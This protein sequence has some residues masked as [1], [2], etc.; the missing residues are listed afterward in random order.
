[1]DAMVDVMGW[2][3]WVAVHEQGGFFTG[4]ELKK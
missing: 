2:T 1:M 3:I 4:N